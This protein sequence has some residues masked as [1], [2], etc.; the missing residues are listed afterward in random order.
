MIELQLMC[1][2]YIYFYNSSFEPK[3]SSLKYIYLIFAEN[4]LQ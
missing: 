4:I 3:I 2:S 1:I